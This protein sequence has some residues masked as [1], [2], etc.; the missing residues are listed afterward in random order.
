[1]P[2]TMYL[3]RLNF[4]LLFLFL[5]IPNLLN[6][7]TFSVEKKMNG[8]LIEN[9]YF[10]ADPNAKL[11]IKDVILSESFRPI[12]E[13][14][15]L[16]IE[17]GA[18]WLRI[19]F[20]NSSDRPI[21]W[22]LQVV[23]HQFDFVDFYSIHDL[24]I[25]KELHIGD[26]RLFEERLIPHG[27]NLYP[28]KI[29]PKEKCRIFIRLAYEKEGRF[30]TAL[31]IWTPKEFQNNSNFYHIFFAGSMIGVFTLVFINLFFY[32]STRTKAYIWYILYQLSIILM[33]CSFT[34]IGYYVI[35]KD[36]IWFTDLI[37]T[38]SPALVFMNAATFTISFL[39]TKKFSSKIDLFLKL[40]AVLHILPICGAILGYKAFASDLV[41]FLSSFLVLYPFLGYYF[42]YKGKREAR[43]YALAWTLWTTGMLTGLFRIAGKI[44]S[45]FIFEVI[46]FLGVILE[47]LF[48]SLALADRINIFQFEK[49]V[50]EKKYTQSLEKFNEDLS[51]KVEEKTKE[52]QLKN[53][54]LASMNKDKDTFLSLIAHDLLGP[55]DSFKMATQMIQSN[56]KKVKLKDK[57]NFQKLLQ[58]SAENIY[59]LLENLLEWA[60]SQKG[61]I[62]F[63]PKELKCREIAEKTIQ[64][65]RPNAQAKQIII[66]NNIKIN[67]SLFAD[68]NLLTTI[69]RNL[70]SNAIKFSIEGGKVIVG[71]SKNSPK[72]ITFFV[73]DNGVGVEK[74]KLKSLFE[75]GVNA[76]ERGT[77]GESGVGLG[78]QICK[79]FTE[80]HGGR[81][82]V[83]SKLGK[84]SIFFFTIPKRTTSSG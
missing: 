35:W 53:Q 47:A 10:L 41:M 78:L 73:Q 71:I 1:M 52:L 46:P 60:K 64:L 14:K 31:K 39:E 18:I 65:L 22:I 16:G 30:N 76:S 54:I 84:G 28:A 33:G 23:Y 44:E 27:S 42:W 9:Y 77:K 43:F 32:I 37:P 3:H 34:G 61:I 55:V 75:P 72:E 20:E 38:L 66:E 57:K 74:E 21:E 25:K 81:I 69:F 11:N 7:Q 58:S 29:S 83:E 12:K 67:L 8:I 13:K 6:A 40:L 15:S 68:E 59:S 19:D 70:I 80:L 56:R 63:S 79:E 49:E 45:T 2:F 24:E 51:L 50:A 4:I 82:W 26:H 36:W 17:P 5:G 48:F 62:V